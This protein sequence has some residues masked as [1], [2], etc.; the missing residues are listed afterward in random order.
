ARGIRGA[1]VGVARV[2]RAAAVAV[3]VVAGGGVARVAEG[4]RPAERAR[5]GGAAA[6]QTAG[7][8]A[9]AGVHLAGGGAGALARD[10]LV[11]GIAAAL[12]DAHRGAADGAVRVVT[13]VRVARVAGARVVTDHAGRR[14][15]GNQEQTEHERGAHVV[16]KTPKW[17]IKRKF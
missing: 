13:G 3:V 8:V 10:V 12:G 7:A 2:E 17:W 4:A 5:A 1:G 9:A 6:A 15:G 16:G 11:A 14:T